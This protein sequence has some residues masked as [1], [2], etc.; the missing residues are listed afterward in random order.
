MKCENVQ[1][2]IADSLMDT[3]PAEEQRDL[4]SHIA[5][6]SVCAEELSKLTQ[7][8]SGLAELPAPPVPADSALRLGKHTNP[9]RSSATTHLKKA[10][11]LV[12]L[13]LL[14]GGYG[15]QMGVR[16]T[17]PPANSEG[18]FIMLVRGEEQNL[19]ASEETLMQEYSAWANSLAERGLFAGGEKLTDEPGRWV[20]SATAGETRSSSDISGYFLITA[21]NYDEAVAIANESPH[22]RYGGSFEIRQIDDL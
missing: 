10:A 20:A 21:R 1:D 11:G 12:G 4:D 22:I 13:L 14:S 3:L 5:T 2:L 6:C 8:W 16:R 17:G 15:Y 9:D 19:R 18:T 7:L